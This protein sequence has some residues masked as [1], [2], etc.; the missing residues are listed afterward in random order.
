MWPGCVGSP[1]IPSARSG[2]SAAVAVWVSSSGQPPKLCLRSRERLPPT[3][4]HVPVLILGAGLAGL[5]AA[6]TCQRLGLEH[7]VLE[8]EPWVGGLCTTLA[9]RGYRFDRTG[10]L[11]HFRDPKRR[12]ET[13]ELLDEEPLHIARRAGIYSEGVFTPYPYQANL[14]GL[15]A[16]VAYQ[17]LLGFVRTRL[18][19]PTIAPRH[20]EE[21]CRQHF[22]DPIAERFMIPY[23]ERLLGVPLDTVTTEWCDRFVPRPSLEDVL[24]GTVGATARPLGYNAEFFYPRRGIGELAAAMARRIPQLL[25][26]QPALRVDPRQ[27]LVRTA[28]HTVS[29]DALVVTLPLPHFLGLLEVEPIAL[30]RQASRLRATHLFY[31]DLGIRGELGRDYHWLYVPERRFP[32]YRVG[33]YSAFSSAMA[34]E[35]CV[36]LYVELA[37]RDRSLAERCLP[38]VVEGLTEM[39]LLGQA[40]QLE[41][42]ALREIAPAYVIYDRDRTNALDQIVPELDQLDI[43][44]AGRYGIWEYSSMEDAL[45]TGELAATRAGERCT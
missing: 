8:R 37:T 2:L 25:L 15:P 29:Y 30:S 21:Y 41:S 1:R 10:H 34:P 20:F 38:Q 40:A 23:N 35:G 22:G 11:L 43:L 5:S 39:G 19:P 33:A 4:P 12:R 42:A 16:D 24:A 9:E 45:V 7:L 6:L 44:L 32:F 28:A 26:G 17:N 31:Y 14:K 13:L 3:T 18:T 27:K 36:N